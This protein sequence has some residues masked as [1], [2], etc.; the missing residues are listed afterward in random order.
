M[1]CRGIGLLTEDALALGIGEETDGGELGDGGV[2]DRV[3]VLVVGL[4]GS[5]V[6]LGAGDVGG[7]GA[8]LEVA[9]G[10]AVGSARDG[11]E[12]TPGPKGSKPKGGK[13][14]VGREGR[15]FFKGV[16]MS[17]DGGRRGHPGAGQ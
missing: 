3:G 1:Q 4:L 16:D 12:Y 6:L 17:D 13:R 15:R 9:G 2:L 7:L 8:L 11:T 10:L 5:V 14:R